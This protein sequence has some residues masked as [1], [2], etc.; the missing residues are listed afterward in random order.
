MSMVKIQKIFSITGRY[1]ILVQRKST[2][3]WWESDTTQIEIV[4][5]GSV[6]CL[7]VTVVSQVIFVILKHRLWN[8]HSLGL[9]QLILTIQ[10]AKCDVQNVFDMLTSLFRPLKYVLYVYKMCILSK[11]HKNP[12]FGNDMTDLDMFNWLW[13]DHVH[14]YLVIVKRTF[15]ISRTFGSSSNSLFF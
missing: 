1:S 5:A 6:Q 4:K 11:S 9:F 8:I 10:R 12:H 15:F 13:I 14:K 2:R 7:T 3:P